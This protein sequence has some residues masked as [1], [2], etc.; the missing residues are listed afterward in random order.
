MSIS[1]LLSD[2]SEQKESEPAR[3]FVEQPGPRASAFHATGPTTY[4]PRQYQEPERSSAFAPTQPSTGSRQNGI[5]DLLNHGPTS[6][7]S[8]QSSEASTP[9]QASATKV[10]WFLALN[11]LI[12]ITE[13]FSNEL[14]PSTFFFFL[15]L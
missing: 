11:D 4:M 12:L 1:R 15:P 7:H 14:F 3:E 5:N 8:A 6:D 13:T 10:S 2:N 9:S